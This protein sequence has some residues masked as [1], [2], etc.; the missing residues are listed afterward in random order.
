MTAPRFQVSKRIPG[1]PAHQ[2]GTSH[3]QNRTAKAVEIAKDGGA[4]AMAFFARVADLQVEDKGPQDFVSEAD[5]AVE[6]RVRAAIETAY[7]DDGIVGEEH[8]P[9]P[10]KSGYTWVIDPIDGTTNFINA[11]PAWT[12]VLTV[13]K[14]DVTQIGVTYDPVHAEIYTAIRGHGAT[15]NG[16]PLICP[17]DTALSRGSVGVGYSNRGHD[18]ATRL[19][20]N[21]IMDHG[22]MFH[23]NASGAL[24]LAY[25]AAGRL[26]GYVEEHMN[27][28]DCLAGQLLI[29]ESGGRVEHQ[30]ADDM[31]AQGGRVVVGNRAV[32]DTLVNIADR[33]F[34]V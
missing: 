26:L 13:V 32:F 29:A 31:I 20:V 19:L 22:A 24:S 34:R 16:A 9:K 33:S 5:K 28:W 3:M 15:L 11:I 2:R 12:V 14:D 8:A 21:D 25:V 18:H 1:Q 23:R 10:S 27:A 17:P 7:P 30:S 4:F 6:L